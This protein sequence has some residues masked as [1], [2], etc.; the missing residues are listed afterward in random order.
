[1]IGAVD[2]ELSEKRVSGKMTDRAAGDR[3]QFVY[4]PYS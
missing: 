4:W 3:R 2:L 1:V